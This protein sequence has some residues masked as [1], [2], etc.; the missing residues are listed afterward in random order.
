MK[1]IKLTKG[2]RMKVDDE[3]YDLLNQW[4][5][6][7][8]FDSHTETFYA[9]RT[10]RSNP[11]KRRTIRVHR[12][13]MNTPKGMYTDHKDG[14][15]L[16]NQKSNLRICTN[17]QNQMNKGSNFNSTSKFKGVSWNKDHNKWS[18]EIGFK[19]K[20]YYLGTFES[21][22]EAAKIYNQ[23]AKELCREFARLNSV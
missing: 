11:K 22:K 21:E 14:D 10:D 5:W 18:V 16:N 19:K 3:D 20:N 15:T 23:K 12:F 17:S 4:D 13:I 7:A 9:I 1:Y 6:Q 2:Q 8:A